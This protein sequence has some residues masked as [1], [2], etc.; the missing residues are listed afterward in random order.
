ML[1]VH[2]DLH[3]QWLPSCPSGPAPAIKTGFKFSFIGFLLLPSTRGYRLVLWL[4]VLLA[5]VVL[6]RGRPRN[7]FPNVSLPSKPGLRCS[8]HATPNQ[9]KPNPIRTII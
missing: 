8:L 3:A 1:L 6:A 5:T 2:P 9:S 7:R 4:Q